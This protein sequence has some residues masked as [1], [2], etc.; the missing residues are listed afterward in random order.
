MK[1]IEEK[2][3]KIFEAIDFLLFLLYL[4]SEIIEGHS[5]MNVGCYHNRR[6]YYF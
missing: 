5:N 2:I 6:K 4:N 1:K 3:W